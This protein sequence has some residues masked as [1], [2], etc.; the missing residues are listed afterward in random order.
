M[1]NICKKCEHVNTSLCKDCINKGYMPNS[2]SV[3]KMS[4]EQ[5]IE[6]N[7]NQHFIN[8][9]NIYKDGMMQGFRILQS[10]INFKQQKDFGFL[11]N[12][13]K[14]NERIEKEWK[15]YVKSNLK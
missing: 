11:D 7:L 3:V 14:I 5:Q 4:E 13:D 10:Y 6:I 8:I 1:K 2:P 15:E 12:N 9:K